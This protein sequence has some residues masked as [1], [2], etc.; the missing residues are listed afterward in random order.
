MEQKLARPNQSVEKTLTI[1]EVMAEHKENMRLQDIA[2][3]AG[4]PTSTALRLINTLLR[5]GY[6]IQDSTTLRYG[7]SLKLAR[8]G[9]MVSSHLDLREL[10]HPILQRL[11]KQ[12]G[13]SCSAAIREGHQVVYIDVVDGPDSI[14]RITQRIGKSAPLYCT[15]IGKLFLSEDPA[16]FREVLDTR[17]LTAFTPNTPV[18]EE[19]LESQVAFAAGGLAYDNE[20]CELG[21]RCVAAPVRDYTGRLAAGISISGPV[22]RLTDDYVARIVSEPLQAAAETLSRQLGYLPSAKNDDRE[23]LP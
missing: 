12:C 8:L 6:V 7:L 22:H 18:T 11:S 23:P 13:E 17:P 2:A 3:K 19:A 9:T 16:L 21:V 4:L 5:R 15:G 20:E 14:L 1:I 10:S